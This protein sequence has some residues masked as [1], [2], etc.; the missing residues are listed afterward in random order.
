M[1]GVIISVWSDLGIYEYDRIRLKF[2][3]YYFLVDGYLEKFYYK[4]GRVV[5]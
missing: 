4:G 5:F 3:V 2:K 1:F